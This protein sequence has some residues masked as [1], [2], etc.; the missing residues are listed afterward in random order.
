MG[1]TAF[2]I[3]TR[4]SGRLRTVQVRVYDRLSDLRNDGKRWAR[5]VGDISE[6]I[7]AAYGLCQTFERVR[8]SDA[9]RV[10]HRYPD[11]GYIRLC[12]KYLRSG[13]ISHEATHMAV[14]IYRQD[15][16]K[17]MPETG[18]QK[19]EDL[20]YLVGDITAKI[21]DKLYGYKLLP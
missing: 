17:L 9:G 10:T 2:Q 14:A 19:N 5:R 7:D 8:T 4:N 11:A 20:C 12:R 21:V 15:I 1:V 18:T 3:S 16:G 6:G 13:I